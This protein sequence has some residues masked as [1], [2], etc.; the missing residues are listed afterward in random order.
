MEE[1]DLVIA[2]GD[3]TAFGNISN[4]EFMSQTGLSDENEAVYDASTTS[5][6]KTNELY[7]GAGFRTYIPCVGDHEIGGNRG[8]VVSSQKSKF[9][10]I[11]FGLIVS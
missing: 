8:F 5:Y 2:P 10:S 4:G 1:T 9:S 3:V 7:Q 11:S 6:T